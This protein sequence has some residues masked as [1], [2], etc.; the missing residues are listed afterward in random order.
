MCSKVKMCGLE[1]RCGLR[2]NNESARADRSCRAADPCSRGS[3]RF[4]RTHCTICVKSDTTDMRFITHCTLKR[5][6]KIDQNP[7]LV[8]STTLCDQLCVVEL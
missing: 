8:L 7:L 4:D 2:W 3:K 6:Q 1:L 5:T